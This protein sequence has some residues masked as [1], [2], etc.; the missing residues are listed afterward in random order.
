M[1][2]A[3]ELLKHVI[4]FRDLDDAELA[5]VADLCREESFMPGEFIFH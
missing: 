1:A 3:S 2:D 5:Q 4:I